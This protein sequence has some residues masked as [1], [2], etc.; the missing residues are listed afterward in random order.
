MT[1]LIFQCAALLLMLFF[2][3]FFSSAE[4]AFFSLSPL[5]LQRLETDYPKGG[6]RVKTA[7]STP[8]QLL[9]TILIGNTI[10]NVS[11]SMLGF[12]VIQAFGIPYST[13]LAVPILTILLLIF[14]E[15]GPKRIALARPDLLTR[16]YASPLL[17]MMK[18]FTP[19]RAILEWITKKLGHYFVPRGHKLSGDEYESVVELSEEE[20]V[21]DEEESNMVQAIFKLEEIKAGEV[22][23][24]RVDIIGYDLE[25]GMAG[26]E[27]KII[28]CRV[29]R[30]VLYHDQL[31][32][33]DGI[34]KVSD[35]LLY[36]EKSLKELIA[37]PFYVP[38]FASL[39]KLLPQFQHEGQR[40]AI[41]VDEYGGTAGIMTRGDI[42][43]E[44]AGD[45]KNEYSSN[46]LHIEAQS[47]QSWIVDGQISLEE[48]EDE[49]GIDLRVEG[50]H[51]LSGW[52][53]AET[54]HILRPGEIIEHRN[55]RIT[56]R[57]MR[58][59]RVT[60]VLLERSEVAL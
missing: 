25:D 12:A 59:H 53:A 44:I 14:G 17:I 46:K 1:L 43:E 48:L 35:Y 30:I 45:L 19:L 41:V 34:L 39:D 23:T 26:L 15:I 51:R 24:P 27:E 8:T 54:G 32:K 11:T 47:D 7:L 42:L 10:I 21:I 2:S 18:I 4:V 5:Q 13:Q 55:L 50:I 29:P 31:D 36:R 16:L 33:I 60:V 38:E 49:L 28:K 57:Q 3:G 37:E 52:M 20:G 56:V 9:S 22:M 40:I 6:K 58:R